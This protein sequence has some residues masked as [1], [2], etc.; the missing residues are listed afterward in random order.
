[1]LLYGYSQPIWQLELSYAKTCLDVLEHCGNVDGVALRIAETIRSY[2]NTLT[3]QARQET[4]LS[5]VEMPDKFD[6][7][8][9]T[10][11]LPSSHL[12]QV[13][14]ELHKLV[15]CPFGYPFNLD[16]AGTLNAGFGTHLD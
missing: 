9:V 11:S 15:S 1:M 4:D 14:W 13:S 3:A 5:V 7:L 10:P 6:Y 2:Y 8:F 12:G 16:A